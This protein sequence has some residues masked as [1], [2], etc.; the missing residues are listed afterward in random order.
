MKYRKYLSDRVIIA[1]SAVPVAVI[2]T[3][4]AASGGFAR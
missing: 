4:V 1:A 3:I 2:V